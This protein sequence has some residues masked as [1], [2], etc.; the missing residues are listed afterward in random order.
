MSSQIALLYLYSI[1]RGL[2][3]HSNGSVVSW[4]PFTIHFVFGTAIYTVQ[5]QLNWDSKNSLAQLERVKA[6]A[7]G[8]H[9]L[10]CSLF[11]YPDLFLTLVG[12]CDDMYKIL[13]TSLEIIIESLSHSWSMNL[14]IHIIHS[15]TGTERGLVSIVSNLRT[16]PSEKQSGEQ[17]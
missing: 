16:P 1:D 7:F 10:S 14:V 9:R 11:I 6:E 17:S 4:L 5:T 8:Q 13:I 15:R 3:C 2:P 12:L